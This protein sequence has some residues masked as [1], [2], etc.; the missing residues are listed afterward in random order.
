MIK[1][2]FWYTIQ[3]F[4]APKQSNQWNCIAQRFWGGEKIRIEKQHHFR[5]VCVCVFVH[6][7]MIS[8]LSHLFN[9]VIG[10]MFSFTFF[11]LFCILNKLVV[12]IVLMVRISIGKNQQCA[13]TNYFLNFYLIHSK[14]RSGDKFKCHWKFMQPDAPKCFY[15]LQNILNKKD[16]IAWHLIWIVYFCLK[17][18]LFSFKKRT[19]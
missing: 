9:I 5:N 4:S 19:F 13:I 8:I 11:F 14:N 16:R 1:T 6:A 17:S 18:I 15:F 2:M 10:Q 12:S 7:L 3:E